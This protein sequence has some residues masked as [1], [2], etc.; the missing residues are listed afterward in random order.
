MT[1]VYLLRPMREEIS[2]IDNNF[3]GFISVK[4]NESFKI[5]YLKKIVF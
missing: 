4:K 2:M 3:N 1:L 5:F